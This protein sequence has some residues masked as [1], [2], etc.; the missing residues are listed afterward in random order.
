M[1]QSE[2]VKRKRKSSHTYG[3]VMSEDAIFCFHSHVKNE[4]CL[5]GV[6]KTG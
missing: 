4:V 1:A 5:D 3:D 2:N 6:F